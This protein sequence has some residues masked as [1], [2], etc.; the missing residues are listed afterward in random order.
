MDFLVEAFC[1]MFFTV[2]CTE[3]DVL[4]S[5]LRTISPAHSSFSATHSFLIACCYKS[6]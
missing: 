6:Y 1:G 2:F 3:P 5:T 4:Q